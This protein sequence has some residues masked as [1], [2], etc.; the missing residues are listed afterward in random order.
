MRVFSS[1][2]PLLLN[3]RRDKE[4][5]TICYIQ[6]SRVFRSGRGGQQG[7]GSDE[8][9]EAGRDKLVARQKFGQVQQPPPG[10]RLASIEK[11]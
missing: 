9:D 1:I 10:G 4:R 3:S 7:A 2:T 11:L 6:Y 5:P 8:G